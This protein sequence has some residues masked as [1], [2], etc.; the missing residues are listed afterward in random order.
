MVDLGVADERSADAL[1]VSRS[2]T[3]PVTAPSKPI[4]VIMST[5]ATR[6]PPVDFGEMSP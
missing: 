5:P 1:R 4:P 6:R 2:A 3:S